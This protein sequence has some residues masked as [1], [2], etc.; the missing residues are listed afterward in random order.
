MTIRALV[1]DDSD[2]TRALLK[3]C[4]VGF[5]D[6][7]IVGEAA[8]GVEAIALAV[9]HEPDVVILDLAMPVMGGMEALPEIRR[10]S[11]GTRVVVFSAYSGPD[12]REDAARLGADAFSVKGINP[13]EL[14][15]LIERCVDGAR[16]RVL[17]AEGE[18]HPVA[19]AAL[20]EGAGFKVTTTRTVPGLRAML[21]ARNFDLAMVDLALE[22]GDCLD[23]LWPGGHSRG[24]QPPVVILLAGGEAP[25]T[26]DRAFGLGAAACVSRAALSSEEL[27]GRVESWIE[28]GANYRS[29]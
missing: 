17:L 14:V 28:Q 16:G 11:P 8:N 10:R 20:L 15:A 4:L 6:F 27:A 13:R 12:V 5:G 25:A 18:D 9:E 26:I 2:D 24:I 21:A 29:G 23:A 7:E 22:G 3:A 1:A 19:Y